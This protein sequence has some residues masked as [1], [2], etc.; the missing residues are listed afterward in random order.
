MPIYLFAIKIADIHTH[1][2]THA[3]IHTI[4]QITNDIET[5]IITFISIIQHDKIWRVY[6]YGYNYL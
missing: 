5:R 1:K 6:I 3:Y 4:T 2:H